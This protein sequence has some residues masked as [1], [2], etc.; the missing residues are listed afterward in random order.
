METN[1]I[2]KYDRSRINLLI[3]ISIGLGLHFGVVIFRDIIENSVLLVIMNI[4]GM[5]GWLVFLFSLTKMVRIQRIIKKDSELQSA[6]NNEWIVLNR[7][8]ARSAGFWI[9]LGLVLIGVILVEFTGISAILVLK[10]ILLIGI[11]SH[12][13]LFILLTKRG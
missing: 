1:L 13:I 4:I 6:L 12:I 5:I 8:K 7:L 2:E 9:F 10:L 11:L 3:G